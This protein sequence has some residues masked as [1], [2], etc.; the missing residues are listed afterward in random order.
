M[1]TKIKSDKESYPEALYLNKPEK[2]IPYSIGSLRKNNFDVFAPRGDHAIDAFEQTLSDR[3]KDN[4][5][6]W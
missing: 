3:L 5:D 1:E 6:D 4:E 2:N